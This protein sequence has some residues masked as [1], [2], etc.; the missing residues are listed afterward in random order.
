M[1]DSQE[2]KILWGMAWRLGKKNWNNLIIPNEEDLPPK[3][4][5]T[6][7]KVPKTQQKRGRYVTYCLHWG[8]I[9]REY[10]HA[11]CEVLSAELQGQRQERTSENLLSSYIQ[12]QLNQPVNKKKKKM[13]SPFLTV[14]AACKRYSKLY[15]VRQLCKPVCLLVNIFIGK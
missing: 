7:R 2:R 11:N 9:S 5:T 3:R 12:N 14:K 1:G 13:F 6:S 8:V 10:K 4:S 15:I